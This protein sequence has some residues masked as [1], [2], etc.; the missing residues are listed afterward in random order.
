MEDMKND[1]RYTNQERYLHDMVF[2]F[3]QYDIPYPA[4]DHCE[5]CWIKFGAGGEIQE[6]YTD[7]TEYRWIC[8]Q[9]FEDFKDLLLGEWHCTSSQTGGTEQTQLQ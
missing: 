2:T 7:E 8:P 5:F 6:G 3:K 1:W 9:C 4:H